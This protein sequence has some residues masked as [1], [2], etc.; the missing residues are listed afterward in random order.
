MCFW[1]TIQ[2]G[3]FSRV[4]GLT[5]AYSN[6][7]RNKINLKTG[8]KDRFIH[9][10]VQYQSDYDTSLVHLNDS[11]LRKQFFALRRPFFK[12]VPNNPE[13]KRP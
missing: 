8:L 3:N 1:Q 7:Q 9:L 12:P 6:K 4:P 10:R 13:F 5:L 2:R 11:R